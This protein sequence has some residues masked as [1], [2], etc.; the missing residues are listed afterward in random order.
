MQVHPFQIGFVRYS[1]NISH[2]K[3]SYE[4]S[5]EFENSIENTRIHLLRVAFRGA[6]LQSTS[7]KLNRNLCKV[8]VSSVVPHTPNILPTIISQ[9]DALTRRPALSFASRVREPL[10][11][12]VT[13]S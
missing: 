9:A 2:S 12:I 3:Y 11:P 13:L 7:E 4:A 6:S 1:E 5:G 10:V 8:L